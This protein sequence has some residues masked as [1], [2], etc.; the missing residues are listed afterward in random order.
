MANH[1]QHSFLSSPA[2]GEILED[3]TTLE[4]HPDHTSRAS[5]PP[6]TLNLELTVRDRDA[7]E[8][9]W[10]RPEGRARTEFALDAMKIGIAALRHA[11][12][13]VDADLVRNA[14]AEL[15]GNLQQSLEQHAKLSH[16][17]TTTV[18]KDYF[19]PQS[20]RLSE[21]LGRLVNHDGELEKLLKGHMQGD[22][23]PLAK[24]MSDVLGRHLGNESPLMRHLDPEQSKGIVA[25]LRTTVDAELS[26]QR[27]QVLSQFSLDNKQSALS[28]LVHELTGKHG[29]LSK[30]LQA[31][32][33]EVIK[34][35]SLD[36]KDSA[37]SRLVGNV[38][39]AQR[40]IQSEFS[41]DNDE[42]GLSRLKKQLMETLESHITTNHKFQEEVKVTLAK[43]T[44]K[45]QSDASSTEHGNVF[46]E[47]LFAFLQ[48]ESQTRGDIAEATGN[49][50]GAIKNCKVGD[51]VL[52]LGSE[53]PAAGARIVFEAKDDRG[54]SLSKAL[55]ELETARKNRRADVGIFIFARNSAP[56]GLRPLARYHN[57]LIVVWDAEDPSTDAYLL[58][59]MEI[60]RACSIEWHRGKGADAVDLEGIEAAINEIE[61]RAIN[62]SQIKKPAETIR[63]SSEKIL[64]RVRIDQEA[65]ERQVKTLREKLVS[66]HA[67]AGE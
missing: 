29:D 1:M 53:S 40:T 7:I 13:Q 39:R 4:D 34:E 10:Q 27:E 42:S 18:L 47:A 65:L 32:I 66:L 52:T 23:S 51:T 45:R 35:F 54:Y 6:A 15:L 22:T 37:L 59:A 31:K 57:D 16:E 26:K 20:G 56:E 14:S 38:E 3:E 55:A 50:T 30:D 11:S 2:E 61:K 41:L 21:R 44:Q 64:E 8:A 46:E 63:S 60:A 58:A 36:K 19:D 48:N 33:D 25:V 12:N 5:D 49:T 43:L 24:T 17:R 67:A 62:L 9:L 28:R